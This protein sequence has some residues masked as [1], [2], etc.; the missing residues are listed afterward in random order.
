MLKE[1]K[2]QYILGK[3]YQSSRNYRTLV[4]GRYYIVAKAIGCLTTSM[5]MKGYD[6]L[7]DLKNMKTHS[8][9]PTE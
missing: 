4:M 3:K 6:G 1:E 2:K 9:S 7:R 5:S 8:A